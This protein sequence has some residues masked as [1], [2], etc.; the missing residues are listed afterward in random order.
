MRVSGDPKRAAGDRTIEVTADGTWRF[1]LPDRKAKYSGLAIAITGTT[2]L[3]VGAV[4]AVVSF[5][6]GRC[7]HTCDVAGGRS[8]AADRWLVA[9]LGMLA[10]GAVLTPVGWSQFAR[11]R[12]PQVE[13]PRER[14]ARRESRMPRVGFGVAPVPGGAAAGVWGRF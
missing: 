10:A 8:E 14:T 2:L 1:S 13:E 12:R 5:H 4:V 3:G 9:G 7:D 11:N 6:S